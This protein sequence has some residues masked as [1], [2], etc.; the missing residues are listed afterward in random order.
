MEEQAC[1]ENSLNLNKH[2]SQAY[3]ERALIRLQL[4]YYKEALNDFI[5]ANTLVENSYNYNN[6]GYIYTTMNCFYDAIHAY[7][8]AL[9]LDKN[10][11]VIYGNR[12]VAYLEIK[13]YNL[14]LKDCL[15]AIMLEP[16][17][18]YYKVLQKKIEDSICGITEVNQSQGISHQWF[19]INLNLLNKI[20]EVTKKIVEVYLLKITNHIHSESYHQALEEVNLAID[21][22]SQDCVLYNT[23]GFIQAKLKRY[24]EALHDFCK[25]M[26]LSPNNPVV[27][28]N[29]AVLY[30]ELNQF[31]K[32]IND[33]DQA[34]LI[35]PENITYKSFRLIIETQIV[36]LKISEFNYSSTVQS[37]VTNFNN[38]TEFIILSDLPIDDKINLLD[39]ADVQKKISQ[40]NN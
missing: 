39:F 25:A 9:F 34:I 3:G 18:T 33:I 6:I 1:V 30:A 31:D 26:H 17:S 28:Y 19:V 7:S 13:E 23:R 38:L 20:D 32:A 12:A 37:K 15:K 24:V 5:K 27:Y 36:K 22:S 21:E 11:A 8:K 35:K 40:K 2:L 14:V 4:K 16:K 29:R 10:Q